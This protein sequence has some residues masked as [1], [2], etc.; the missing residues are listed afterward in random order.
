M[1]GSTH[2]P[3]AVSRA[4]SIWLSLPLSGFVALAII[5]LFQSNDVFGGALV[6]AL[7]RL[8]GI[9]EHA[10]HDLVA[11]STMVL[12][13][14]TRWMVLVLTMKWIILI[15]AIVALVF[16]AT[17]IFLRLARVQ[18]AQALRDDSYAGLRPFR[19]FVLA[20]M[21]MLVMTPIFLWIS[22]S[23]CFD[24]TS[25]NFACGGS[26]SLL[27]ASLTLASWIIFTARVSILHMVDRAQTRMLASDNRPES[28]R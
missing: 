17:E 21:G 6:D 15:Y 10:A 2:L 1:F 25:L 22:N 13:R 27:L 14:W 28:T 18:S 26:L 19:V 4:G 16:L 5:R 8:S 7:Q 11:A 9:Q 3:I 20:S 23:T 24:Q 12:D